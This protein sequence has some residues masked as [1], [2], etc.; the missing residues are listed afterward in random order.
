MSDEFETRMRRLISEAEADIGF[1]RD[2]QTS[3]LPQWVPNT[4]RP[5]RLR[6]KMVCVL[7]AAKNSAGT[8][9]AD[10]KS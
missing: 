3:V 5:V 8:F 7:A 4:R 2:R 1:D 9:L 6:D 10:R